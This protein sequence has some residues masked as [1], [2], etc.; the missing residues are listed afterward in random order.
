MARVPSARSSSDVDTSE[1]RESTSF[2]DQPAEESFPAQNSEHTSLEPP[3]KCSDTDDQEFSAD[4]SML[5]ARQLSVFP[6]EMGLTFQNKLMQEVKEIRLSLSRMNEVMCQGFE[7]GEIKVS[8]TFQ[9]FLQEKQPSDDELKEHLKQ[10]LQQELQSSWNAMCSS[11]CQRIRQI[12]QD[13]Q[14]H[15]SAA[16]QPRMQTPHKRESSKQVQLYKLGITRL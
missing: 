9:Q 13:S 10:L 16:A 3:F 14:S 8:E 1:P 7:K 11:L 6:F 2:H 15:A 4:K 5:Q 12:I